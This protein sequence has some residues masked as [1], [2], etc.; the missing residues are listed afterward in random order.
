[1]YKN[2]KIIAVLPAYNA[3]LTLE[4]T[5]VD[6]PDIF[7]EIIL[8]D[9]ASSDKTVA[10]AKEL[11][12]TVIVHDNNK[13][14]G[15]NQKTCYTAALNNGADVVVMIHPD[16]QYDPKLA[17]YFVEYIVDGYFDVLLGNRIRSR[18]EALEGGM[19]AYKYLSNR[20]LT[21]FENIVSGQNL[22]EWH[23]G[24]RAY[25]RSVLEK[26]NYQD[27]SD[28]FIFDSQMLFKIISHNFKI[29]EVPVPVIYFKE[30]SS[31]SFRHSLK[32][33]LGT[34]WC[35]LKYLFGAYR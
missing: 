26:I 29:G 16:Y 31:I 4:K 34:V 6:I 12:V 24:M 14:Y 9:D 11:G 2:K 33:G 5:I 1:M 3:A 8:V 27:N 7:D 20:L 13:G 28:S 15:G 22:G 30:A 23:S 35:G 10:I 25:S 18:R 21:L 19:P 32:Y 17:R